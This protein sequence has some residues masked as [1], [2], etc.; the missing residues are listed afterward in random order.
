MATTTSA[1]PRSGSRPRN[2]E[3]SADLAAA[4][5]GA[6]AGAAGIAV[7]ELVAGLVGGAP[8]LVIA[9][10]DLL[11]R[12]QPP[13]AKDAVVDLFGTNDKLA[14]NIAIVVVAVVLAAAIGVIGRHRW[15]L[16][17]AALAALALVLGFAAF[18]EPLTAPF[19]AVL[20]PVIGFAVALRVLQSL[21]GMIPAVPVEAVLESGNR[22]SRGVPVRRRNGAAGVAEM[23]DWNWR[24]F[25]LASG[26]IAIGSLAV[27]A[28]GRSLLNR[29]PDVPTT[30]QPVQ[31]PP[32]AASIAPLPPAASL[33]VNGITPIVMPN[34]RFYRIDTALVVPRVDVST[35]KLAVTGLVNTE[36]TFT[37]DQLKAL[38]L[39]QQYVTIACVSN[40]VGE[41]LV[42]NAKWT[43]VHLRDVLSGAGVRPEATQIVGRSVDGFTVGFPTEWAMDPAR[44]PMVAIGMNDALLPAEHG[45]PARLIVPGLYGYVSATKWLAEIELTTLEAFD[46]Y[47][48]PLGW[49]KLGPILTQSRID[50]PRAGSQLAPGLVPVAGVAWAPD[51]GISKVE[52][53]VDSGDWQP[54]VLSAAIS[55][56][57]WVQ[58]RYDWMATTGAHQIEVRATDGTGEV[59]TDTVT[60]PAPDGA[61]GHHHVNVNVG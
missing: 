52:I 30:A 60:P 15:N 28:L 18:T 25:L 12:L 54:A 56:A 3:R 49:S 24:R 50:V 35:W 17:V 51:R 47:W 10:G 33:D 46:A 5:A 45:Y 34:D 32:T 59:Q 43:G 22:A 20:T 9:L 58:W 23:P 37:Y 6:V 26:S 13:G 39:F 29:Q 61:R 42:G 14:L 16:A 48:I 36:L 1:P 27:G 8:S 4:L 38:G 21:L 11:I 40:R 57:T 53:R 41:D 19:L 44:D 55:K 2:A 7:A 31:L